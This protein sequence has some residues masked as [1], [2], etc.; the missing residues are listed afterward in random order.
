MDWVRRRERPDR[1][2]GWTRRD[3]AAGLQRQ[4]TEV[5]DAPDRIPH[6]SKR[7]EGRVLQ[8]LAGHGAPHGGVAARPNWESYVAGRPAW[9]VLLDVDRLARRGGGHPWCLLR[10]PAAAAG[11]GPRP[12]APVPGRWRRRRR[13]RVRPRTTRQFVP[14]AGRP[15]GIDRSTAGFSLPVAKTHASWIDRDHLLVGT[16]TDPGPDGGDATRSSYTSTLRVLARG[17]SPSRR[18]RPCSPWTTGTWRPSAATT[19]PRDGN[20]PWRSTRS[21]S[22][23]PPR[24]CGS[25]GRRGAPAG[26]AARRRPRG[27][28]GG[29]APAVAGAVP[30]VGTG[31]G[32]GATGP[33]CTIRPGPC[34]SAR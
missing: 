15:G 16:V 34:S 11:L 1:G 7:G 24:G 19:P 5:L 14:D 25:P 33:P 8:L 9:E 32:A 29:R 4:V 6:V 21:T 26:L 27:R 20:A 17:R 22:P 30:E 18:P 23:A 28:G 2:A 10:C 12:A 31:T 3:S 13:P